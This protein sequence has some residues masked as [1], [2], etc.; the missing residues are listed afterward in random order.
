MAKVDFSKVSVG[1]KTFLR[2]DLLWNCIVNIPNCL[3]QAT[4][5]IADD[6]HI[7]S[8][9]NYEYSRLNR[10]GHKVITLNFD[11]GFGKKSNEIVS[12]L[13]TPY[14]LIA[15]DDFDFSD[16][17]ARDGVMRM[18][19]TLDEYPDVDIVS[20]R[21]NNRAYEFNLLDEGST[22]TEQA[23]EIP[24]P[25]KD[26]F[27][28]CDLTVNYS[29]IRSCVFKKVGW[30]DDVKIGGGEHGAFFVDV[31]RAGFKV[32][33]A[34]NVNIN[35]QLNRRPSDEYLKFRNRARS[36]ERSCFK[37]RGIKKYILVSGQVD[38]DANANRS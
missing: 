29:L 2:D 20:G 14:L 35:E 5:I 19:Y 12:V 21:V 32:V 38:Y 23:V 26:F 28:P 24:D 3:P 22:I 6:G 13:D 8:S 15:S 7:D 9:K 27:Y 16:I 37:K 34:P 31:K 36:P 10:R 30:D 25:P 33:F 4:M 11:S 18:L 17:R 1:I